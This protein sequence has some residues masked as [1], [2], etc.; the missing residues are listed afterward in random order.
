MDVLQEVFTSTPTLSHQGRGGLPFYID[1]PDGQD[2]LGV[3]DFTLTLALSHQGRGD[4][5]V[6]YRGR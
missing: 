2:F 5:A 6:S 1:G 3:G 4:I